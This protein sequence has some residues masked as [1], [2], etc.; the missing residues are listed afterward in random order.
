M[1]SE[2]KDKIFGIIDNIVIDT[3]NKE[4]YIFGKTKNIVTIEKLYGKTRYKEIVVCRQLCEYFADFFFNKVLA[5]NMTLEAIGKQY[6]R[7]HCVVIHS[8]S[9]I[10][11]YLDTEPQILHMAAFCLDKITKALD[12]G[13]YMSKASNNLDFGDF[14]RI[15]HL[16]HTSVTKMH[17][18]KVIGQKQSNL[19]VDV[20][21][22]DNA[23]QYIHD[24]ITTV[25]ACIRC[26]SDENEVFNYKIGDVSKKLFN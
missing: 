1:K 3:M 6:D 11:K 23:E 14:C 22:K 5:A 21:V 8:K 19:Y 26:G 15:A 2:E 9:T 13:E 16:E 24:N 4:P 25:I 20:P 12:S 7:G 10:G 18:Y 17:L